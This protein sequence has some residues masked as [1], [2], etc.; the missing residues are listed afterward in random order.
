VLA[1]RKVQSK[2][3]ALH[4]ITGQDQRHQIAAKDRKTMKVIVDGFSDEILLL[5][6]S[7]ADAPRLT[8]R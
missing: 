2:S 3:V 1:E 8:A 5:G 7:S 6:R 4:A